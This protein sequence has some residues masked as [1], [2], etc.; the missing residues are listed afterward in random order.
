MHETCKM[1]RQGEQDMPGLNRRG[2]MNKGPMTGRGRG[3]CTGAL[4]PEQGSTVVEYNSMQRGY[5]RRRC[6]AS[7]W[8]MRRERNYGFESAKIDTNAFLQKS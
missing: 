6:Q 4:S 5:G 3:L 7:G 8:G 2:P 1:Q